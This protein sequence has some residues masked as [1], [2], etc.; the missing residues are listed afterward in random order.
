MAGKRF[1][2]EYIITILPWQTLDTIEEG[3]SACGGQVKG[4]QSAHITQL[5]A[6]LAP[7]AGG[8]RGRKIHS[9]AGTMLGGRSSIGLMN[10]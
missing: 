2:P 1:S 9:R 8:P 10:T 6:V 7:G 4:L 3:E 5:V